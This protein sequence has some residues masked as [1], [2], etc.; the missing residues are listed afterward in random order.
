MTQIIN[1]NMKNRKVIMLHN[2]W[3]TV[4]AENINVREHFV[5]V[6]STDFR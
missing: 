5:W 1:K 3:I 2:R 6:K 4:R